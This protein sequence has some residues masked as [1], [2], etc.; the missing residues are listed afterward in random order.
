M[1]LLLGASFVGAEVR[2]GLA[3]SA[4]RRAAKINEEAFPDKTAPLILPVP[5]ALVD[6]SQLLWPFGVQGGGHPHGHPG[7][8]FDT[9]LGAPVLAAFRGRV[10]SV[11]DAMEGSVAEKVIEIVDSQYQS[12]YIG[13]MVNVSV[14]PGDFVM[15]GQKIAELG[16]FGN[17]SDPFGFIHWGVYSL[18][19]QQ[20]VCGYE[21]MSPAAKAELEDIH[22]RSTYSEKTTYP[23]ICNP[24]PSGGC[25]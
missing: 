23:L 16:P 15:Q 8:D 11:T 22:A 1:G 14:S 5:A 13:P 9:E 18:A 7:F 12:F 6:R 2:I 3:N 17:P 25:R 4:A 20:P 10:R 19:S 24:C 21:L